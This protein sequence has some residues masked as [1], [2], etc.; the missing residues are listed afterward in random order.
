MSFFLKQYNLWPLSYH[1]D[2]EPV[3]PLHID[4]VAP[5]ALQLERQPLQTLR[6]GLDVIV[7]IPVLF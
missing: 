6:G 7:R 2:R 1:E 5:H 4:D 3:A